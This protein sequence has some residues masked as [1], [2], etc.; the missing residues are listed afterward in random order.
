[1][2]A[3]GY[4][5]PFAAA[6]PEA[7]G[8]G[9]ARARFEQ[10]CRD[11]GHEL[12]AVLTPTHAVNGQL[13]SDAD[14]FSSLAAWC[15]DPAAAPGVVLMPDSTH[16]AGDLDKFVDRV[17]WLEERG[18][19]VRCTI[20]PLADPLE[21]GL[22][23]LP[24]A[25]GVRERTARI[26]EAVAAKASRGEVLGRTPYGYRKGLDGLLEPVD[27][28]AQIVREVFDLYTRGPRDG[29][30]PLGLRRIASLLNSRGTTTRAGG[31]WSTVSLAG[32][33]RNPVYTGSYRR[34]SVR[35]A[36][37]HAPIVDSVMF[38]QAQDAV[39]RRQPRRRRRTREP[40]L[41]AGLAFCMSCG[42][43]LHGLLRQR[44]W[45]R[46]DGGQVTRTYRYYECPSRPQ[47]GVGRDVHASWRAE[48]LERAV[49][50]RAGEGRAGRRVTVSA[51]QEG[52]GVDDAVRRLRTAIRRVAAGTAQVAEFTL[53]RTRL[54]RARAAGSA[55]A[56]E[57]MSVADAVAVA[58]SS[59]HDLAHRAVRALI[60][61]V[62]VGGAGAVGVKLG[63]VQSK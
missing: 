41:L 1:V 28:E 51:R 31:R 48:E 60:D 8:S 14:Q 3:V 5:R 15:D 63:E 11:R 54:R 21:N 13:L 52:A 18:I 40:Y 44:T 35:I 22:K 20:S 38:Q 16:L 2:R 53:A 50:E 4:L 56:G 58:S 6:G 23:L 57:E 7:R 25:P 26:R 32:V 37:N 19:E 55:A 43:A 33:L 49:M 62:R 39:A 36:S 10:Y 24:H 12:V 59:D 29:G 46:A 9:D 61:T 42:R 17:L 45:R 27:A 30:G 34:R 47:S